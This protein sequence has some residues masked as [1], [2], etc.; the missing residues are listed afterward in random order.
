RDGSWNMKLA[1]QVQMVPKLVLLFNDPE[2]TSSRVSRICAILSHLLEDHFRIKDYLWIGLFLVYTLG[3]SSLEES[4]TCLDNVTESINEGIIQSS[5]KMIWLRNQL[6]NMLLE[7]IQSNKFQLS[8]EIQEEAFHA[9]GPDWFLMFIQGHV[10]PSTVVL[11]IRLLLHFLQNRALLRTFKEGMVT[12]RWIENNAAGLNIL[13]ENLKSFPQ[14]SE[15]N[16]Y[17][18]SGFAEL[19]AFLRNWIHIPEI[20]FFLSGLFL[21]T[22]VSQLPDKTKRDLNSLLHWLL[23]NHRTDAV[24][25]IGLCLEAGVLLLEMIKST[26]NQAPT[27]TEDSW[28]ITYP[29]H[30]MQFFCLVYHQYPQDSLW[31]NCDFLQALALVVFPLKVPQ[32]SHQDGSSP[33]GLAVVS[34]NKSHTG[35]LPPLLLNPARKQVWDFIRLLLMEMLLLNSA[36]EWWH[37]LEFLLEAS[38]DNSTPEQKR[39][40]QTELLLSIIDIFYVTVQDGGTVKG[41]D[42]IQSASETTVPF[43]VNVSYVTQILVEKLYAGMLISEPRKI[44]LFLIEHITAVTKKDFLHKEAIISD[45][46]LSLNRIIL[47]YLSSSLS[48]HQRLLEV[49]HTLQLQW[50]IV[51]SV[52][53]SSLGFVTCLLYCLLLTKTVSS[54]E[55]YKAKERETSDHDMCLSRSEEEGMVQ[56]EIQKATEEIWT[57]LLSQKGKDLE[58]AYK[59]TLSVQMGDGDE[60]MKMVDMSPLWKEILEEAWHHF[61]ASEKKGPPKVV[62]GQGSKKIIS[63]SGS[64]SSTAK[65]TSSR[66]I[67]QMRAKTKDFVSCLEESR[68][69]GQELYAILCK[70]HAERLLCAYNKSAKAWTNTE[71]QLFGK[72]AP[73]GPAL[74]SSKWI[75]DEFE[76]PARMRKRIQLIATHPTTLPL[77]KKMSNFPLQSHQTYENASVPEEN[78]EMI[79]KEGEREMDCDQLTFFPSLHE[80]FHSEELFEVCMERNIILQEFVKDEKIRNRQSVV[81]VQGHMALEGVLLFGQE[82]FYVCK[83]FTLSHL[84]EVYCSRHC[85]SSISDSF[86]YDLCHKEQAMEQPTCSCYSYCDIK[87][88]QP[89]R[90]LLQ[91]VA[92]EIFFRHGRSV[93]L[94]FHNNDRKINL[95]R[96]YSMRPDLKSKGITDESINI[97]RGGGREKTMLL[98]WQRREISNFEYLMYLNTLAGRTYSDL[99][100]YPVFPWIL[101]DYHSQTLD[102]NNPSTFRDLSKPM[103]AQ[104][105]ERKMKFIQRYKEVEKSEGNLSAQCHY[106]THY[107]SAII[108]ASYLVRIEPFTRIFCSLQGGGFDAADRMFH[109]IRS[110]WESASRDN[111]TDV[112]ELIPEFFY[113]PEFL[114]N[115][116]QFELGSLQD[117]TPLGDI[118]LPPWA[119]GNPYKFVSL[120]RQALESDYVS[121]HLHHWIDLIFGCKQQGPA[122]VK[123]VN[124]FHPYFYGDQIHLDSIKDPLIKN[125]ILGY[126]SN[127][128]QIPR[129]LFTK[130]H[131]TRNALGKHPVGRE[132]ILFPYPAGQLPPSLKGLHHL[133]LSSVTVKEA[134]QEPIGHM[135]CTEKGILA[136][137]RNK[138]LLPPLWNKVFCWGFNDFTCCLTGYGSDKN[139][140]TFEVIADWGCCLCAVSPTPS[141]LITSG[142]S[143]VICVWELSTPKDGATY[144][145]LK[146]P[147]YGHTQPVTC[148]AA[149]TSY[150]ILVSGSA[151]RSC[152]I[153]DLNHLTHIT[154][155]PAHEAC[156]SAVAINDSTGDVASCAGPVLYL[157]N[158]NGQPLARVSFAASPGVIFSCC[159]FTE[160]ID[161]DVNSLIITGDT[162]GGVQVWKLENSLCPYWSFKKSSQEDFSKHQPTEGKKVEMPFILHQELGLS[163]T[164]SERASKAI[165]AVTALAVSRNYSKILAGNENGKIYCW[166]VDE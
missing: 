135:I 158:V 152:I 34:G 91:E 99:M 32:E 16:S 9:L 20:Y 74:I 150:S 144:L 143:S 12:G 22:P 85:L 60:K 125:T 163:T 78:Q 138:M 24:S 98:K 106:C 129:Q 29:E 4:H 64:L 162:A 21:A 112:R 127:F 27:G 114:T 132:H 151:D 116:N 48:E 166:S 149:S 69:H 102:L 155:L 110:T 7:V 79:L 157:W 77:R 83:Y 97:R 128:G 57:R 89:L 33:N 18:L 73:W 94:V 147:L 160:V 96:F 126:V 41:N 108:V 8:S 13:M 146:K 67:K 75:L 93:F 103:G 148:L 92:F 86:I 119:E 23:H 139:S 159:C 56:Q 35:L 81:I 15:H 145:C 25:R 58:D 26:V 6:L 68:R 5:R 118:Q 2:I 45:L 134:P 123:A 55:D 121:A 28:E 62:P 165:P 3:P 66:N 70:D 124:V 142:S 52:H 109:S 105:L 140:T 80:S 87:E 133:K 122:A 72:G 42:D 17:P 44:L 61:L 71:T 95:K 130:T 101:A 156:L 113:F 141:T 54:P 46:Y 37:P 137:E 88:I 31:C 164:P 59:T 36:H 117:G 40:F 154:Q 51:F 100:Q 65:M 107:S 50:D 84:E 38:A 14:I 19:K 63:W 30:I 115:C 136:V 153:W 43:L 111:M 49:L 76:G 1:R 161:W 10:H 39:C 11:A 104:T 82:H 47:Y 53:N 120:H 90:F 131:P